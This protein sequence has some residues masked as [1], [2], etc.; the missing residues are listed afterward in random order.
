VTADGTRTRAR[1]YEDDA[2]PDI[3]AY[4]VDAVETPVPGFPAARVEPLPEVIREH[5]VRTPVTDEL[6]A[7]L[8]GD[9][10]VLP[11]GSEDA[12]R[13]ACVYLA[14]WEKLTERMAAG[15]PPDGWYPVAFYRDDLAA[16]DHLATAFTDLIAAATGRFRWAISRVDEKFKALT[17]A[18]Q[19]GT[20]PWW[21]HRRPQAPGLTDLR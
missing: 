20:D 18:T 12:V 10:V 9:D 7:W 3:A 11:A 8:A 6:T 4:R 21:H 1:V 13:E 17:T 2:D 14:V 5:P 19:P 16:R 15:W